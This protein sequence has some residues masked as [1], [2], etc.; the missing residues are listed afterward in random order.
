MYIQLIYN[1]NIKSLRY[2]YIYITKYEINIA[3]L[4]ENTSIY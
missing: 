4:I 3:I 1:K 2:I